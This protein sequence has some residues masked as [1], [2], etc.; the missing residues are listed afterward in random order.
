MEDLL[1]KNIAPSAYD[2]P[3]A[4][5]GLSRIRDPV[6]SD[7]TLVHEVPA[8]RAILGLG[9]FITRDVRV[10]ALFPALALS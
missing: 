9:L 7:N 10:D 1:G 2:T 3:L 4:T 8:A 5:D 6:S